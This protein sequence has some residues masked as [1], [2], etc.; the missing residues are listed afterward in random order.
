MTHSRPYLCECRMIRTLFTAQCWTTSASRQHTVGSV[1]WQEVPQGALITA[2]PIIH[3]LK[4]ISLPLQVLS[5][6]R[7]GGLSKSRHPPRYARRLAMHLGHDS[8]PEDH[9]GA[10]SGTDF[11]A[12]K[13]GICDKSIIMKKKLLLN[14]TQKIHFH[15]SSNLQLRARAL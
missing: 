1:T 15:C 8:N 7:T 6:E 12:M 4:N 3:Q 14:G 11:M 9:L 13:D 5:S 10:R 2:Q